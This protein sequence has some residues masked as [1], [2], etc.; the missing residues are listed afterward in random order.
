MGFPAYG[1]PASKALRDILDAGHALQRLRER[2]HPHRIYASI[3]YENGPRLHV[4]NDVTVCVV[5]GDDGLRY[6]WQAPQREPSSPEAIAEQS[7]PLDD[8]D[9]AAR[10]IAAFCYAPPRKTPAH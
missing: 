2:L 6:S 1:T 10:L 3:S 5:P 9:E 7:A 4:A 8:L